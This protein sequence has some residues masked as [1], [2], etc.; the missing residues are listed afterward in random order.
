MSPSFLFQ[1]AIVLAVAVG[2][3]LYLA[4]TTDEAET[5][6][7][8]DAHIDAVTPTRKVQKPRSASVMSIPRTKG[9]FYAQG[10]VNSGNVRFLV[11]TGASAVALTLDDARRAGLDV[12]TL[13]YTVPVQTANGQALAAQ[14]TLRDVRLGGVVVRDVPA[15][16]MQDGLHIS[17]L[18]MSFLGRLQTVEATPTQLILRR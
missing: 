15:L 3:T 10:R 2:G 11:D 12:R 9:Q 14:V 13:A 7:P 1:V 4:E 18:G 6:A 16:V 8:V 17:L 5:L